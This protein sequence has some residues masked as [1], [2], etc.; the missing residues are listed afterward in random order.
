MRRGWLVASLA[1]AALSV[2]AC[3]GGD[4]ISID[5]AWARNSPAMATAGAVYMDIT[6]DADDK[7]VGASVDSS[8]AGTVEVHEVVM[9]DMGDDSMSSDDS[10]VTEEGTGGAMTM[11]PVESID[12]P[13]GE[14][15]SLMPG[16]YHIMLLDLAA[17]LELGDTISVTLMFEQTDDMTVDV[18]VRDSAP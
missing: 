4:E 1:V 13:A 14:T 9:A 8:I 5:R 3:G 16:G 7:L 6:S 15:V 12:L 10:M 2:G 11:Q 17:P 18:E